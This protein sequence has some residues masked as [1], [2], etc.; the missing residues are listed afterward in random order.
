MGVNSKL[1]NGSRIFDK[2]NIT[3]HGIKFTYKRNVSPFA[4]VFV[5]ENNEEALIYYIKR[6]RK[7]LE[8]FQ[9]SFELNDGR[10]FAFHECMTSCQLD[11]QYTQKGLYKY[12]FQKCLLSEYI[13]YQ[14]N[15]TYLRSKDKKNVII[16]EKNNTY[17]LPHPISGKN[18]KEYSI[19]FYYTSKFQTKYHGNIRDFFEELVHKTNQEYQNSNVSIKA[20]MH[21]FE[22]ATI[23]ENISENMSEILEEFRKMKGTTEW[24]RNLADVAVLLINDVKDSCGASY[25]HAYR[26]GWTFSVVSRD[27]AISQMTFS[28]GIAHNFGAIHSSGYLL[29]KKN[30]RHGEEG[31]KSRQEIVRMHHKKTGIPSHKKKHYAN[32]NNIQPVMKT[33]IRKFGMHANLMYFSKHIGKISLLG[34]ESCICYKAYDMREPIKSPHMSLNESCMFHSGIQKNPDATPFPTNVLDFVRKH[35]KEKKKDQ[36]HD[37]RNQSTHSDLHKNFLNDRL[38][39]YKNYLKAAQELYKTYLRDAHNK[40]HERGYNYVHLLGNGD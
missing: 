22:K 14:F 38:N 36:T 6:T 21:C 12:K 16:I 28:H 20:R 11:M 7:G 32:P 37:K 39:L 24:L 5:T 10:S 34:N 19:M 18:E 9:G 4:Y 17:S 26:N 13:F 25:G 27:C 33:R 40:I 2:E 15:Q 31:K 8:R 29:N 23:R 35:R 3:I 1:F 30:R